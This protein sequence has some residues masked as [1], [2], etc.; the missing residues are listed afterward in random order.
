MDLFEYQKNNFLKKESPLAI[1]LRPKTLEDFIGQEHIVGPNTLLNR[2]IRADK[3][4]SL[5]FY[6][7]PGTGKTSLAKV[8]ANTTNA[9]FE[10]INA[11]NSGTKDIKKIIETAEK[12]ISFINK[13][14]ILF[15]DEI[16]RFNKAQQDC[17]LPAVEQGFIILIGATTENPYFEVN[18]ALI[19][20]SII[21]ELK[22]LSKKSIKQII[23]NAINDKKNGFGNYKINIFDDALD[24]FADTSNGDA[25]VAL[26]ALEI[27]VLTTDKSENSEIN[28]NLEVASQCLQKK[29]INYDKLGDNHYDTIS[30]F[31]KSM[32]GSDPDAT[33]HYLA[34]MLIAGEDIKFIARRIII[35]ASEDVGN[36]DPRALQIAVAALNAVDYVGMPEGRIILAQAAIYVASAPKSNSCYV[37]IDKAL[38]DA[39]KVKTSIPNHLKDAHYLGAKNLGHGLGYKYSHDYKNNYVKQNYLPKELK[40]IIYYE[41]TQNGYEK[42]ISKWLNFLKDNH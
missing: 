15:I 8:I 20:R 10:Q 14:T 39:N 31:I 33:V 18:K 26:N 22:P 41:P 13:K 12:N 16:H 38:N 1:R 6:G 34:K 2:A 42:N 5:I 4:T 27:A 29:P 17:L 24:F 30:A 9:I 11:T 21:Y 35:C 36:A 7:P 25:R 3:L 37:A 23:T 32:R 28:I 19:S 40:N